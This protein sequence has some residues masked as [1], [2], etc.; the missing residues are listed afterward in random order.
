MGARG[1]TTSVRKRGISKNSLRPNTYRTDI[2][3]GSHPYWDLCLGAQSPDGRFWSTPHDPERE[4]AWFEL[5]D[6]FRQRWWYSWS[7]GRRLDGWICFELPA[8]ISAAIAAGRF[9][10]ADVQKWSLEEAVY[11]LDA[12]EHEREAIERGWEHR[13][14]YDYVLGKVPQW[15]QDQVN[16]PAQVTPLPRR[17]ARG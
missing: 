13:I 2:V 16:P 12:D 14:R 17:R 8:L 3:E 1:P 15:F 6:H 7:N 5:R 4:R 9:T 10:K 11:H